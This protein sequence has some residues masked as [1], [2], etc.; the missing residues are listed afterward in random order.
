MILVPKYM[1]VNDPSMISKQAKF[2]ILP[3]GFEDMWDIIDIL[4]NKKPKLQPAEINFY[5][6]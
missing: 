3:S 1:K 5:T 4:A 6:D 2:I